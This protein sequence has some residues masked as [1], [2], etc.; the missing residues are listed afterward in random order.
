MSEGIARMSEAIAR[1]DVKMRAIETEF[2][3]RL[4]TV[5]NSFDEIKKGLEE[6]TREFEK[7]MEEIKEI[8]E[9]Y[10]KLKLE[11]EEFSQKNENLEK[12]KMSLELQIQKVLQSGTA[13]ESLIQQ[14]EEEISK[15]K[16][17]T[18]Q[19]RKGEADTLSRLEKLAY[20]EEN[21]KKLQEQHKKLQQSQ[22][23]KFLLI[24]KVFGATL[25]EKILDMLFKKPEMTRGELVEQTGDDV[26]NV[27]RALNE[28]AAKEI[29]EYD[30]SAG[31]AKF[32][33]T[34]QENDE[35]SV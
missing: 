20:L 27:V 35:K 19:A 14:K 24:D 8:K 15:L 25:H 12:E 4:K 34:N 2:L 7:G 1:I 26:A 23:V 10:D 11:K 22:K 21:N 31:E 16:E 9:K 32:I 13:R 18:E 6:V 28:L 17:E 30:E 33:V 29:I 5:N 3:E